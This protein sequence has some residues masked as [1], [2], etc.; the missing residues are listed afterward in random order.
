MVSLTSPPAVV[1][2]SSPLAS[3]SQPR[4]GL[5]ALVLGD[6]RSGTGY[7]LE[8]LRPAYRINGRCFRLTKFASTPGSDPEGTVYDLIICPVHGHGSHQC[9]CRGWL[10]WGHCRHVNALLSLVLA[11]RL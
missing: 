8:E 11:G 6:S 2:R 9:D 7:W 5:R 10:R 3:L 4:G 1:N